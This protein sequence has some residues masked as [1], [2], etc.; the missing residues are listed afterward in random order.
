MHQFGDIEL[1]LFDKLLC[2]VIA[3][4]LRYAGAGIDLCSIDADHADLEQLQFLGHQQYL[5]KACGDGLEVLA[6]ER[7]DGVVIGMRVGRHQANADIAVGGALD[8]ATGKNAVGITIDHKRQHQARMILR[9]TAA[10]LVH[11]EGRHVNALDRLD[12]EMR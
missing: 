8:T 10:A 11:F 2:A 9:R 5:Q 3:H 7:G 4:A 1:Q 6:P 12:H